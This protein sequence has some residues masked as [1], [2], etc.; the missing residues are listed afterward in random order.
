MN[1]VWSA[2]RMKLKCTGLTTFFRLFVCCLG[3]IR[4][5][6][7]KQR[8]ILIR[9]KF[10]KKLNLRMVFFLYIYEILFL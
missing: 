9:R 8:Y 6:E 5:E 1:W 2:A 4:K 10:V 3:A 7:Y